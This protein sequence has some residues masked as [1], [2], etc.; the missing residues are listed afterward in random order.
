LCLTTRLCGSTRWGTVLFRYRQQNDK[1]DHVQEGKKDQQPHEP[2][3]FS[4]EFPLFANNR[5]SFGRTF[6]SHKTHS[7]AQARWRTYGG[8]AH[9]QEQRLVARFAEHPFAARF[10]RPNRLFEHNGVKPDKARTDR[11]AYGFVPA[12]SLSCCSPGGDRSIISWHHHFGRSL[13]FPGALPGFSRKQIS[14]LA[15]V[16]LR[17]PVQV[18]YHIESI[19][20]F[21]GRVWGY[22]S[23]DAPRPPL[24]KYKEEVSRKS[25]EYRHGQ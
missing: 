22:W 23:A 11:T 10:W 1:Y 8:V 3:E 24:C 15:R 21:K 25:Y 2:G 14:F 17:C 5:I 19:S 6:G 7:N 18:L 13:S 9:F 4:L 20:S 12:P 16:T